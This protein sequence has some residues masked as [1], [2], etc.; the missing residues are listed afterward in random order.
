MPTSARD[1][2]NRRHAVISLAAVGAACALP[3]VLAQPARVEEDS[4]QALALG[5]KHD[6]T[7]VDTARYPKHSAQQHCGNCAFWQGKPDEAWAG[8]AMFG[9]RQIA[10][11]GWC[12][13]WAKAPG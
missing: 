4:E 8:C 6:T 3:P 7:R 13:A 5:Y 12:Q 11:R 2:L 10:N 1:G 9:R